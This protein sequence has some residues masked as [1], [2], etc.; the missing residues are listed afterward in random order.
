[1]SM[2]AVKGRKKWDGCGHLSSDSMNTRVTVNMTRTCTSVQLKA[3]GG[4]GVLRCSKN[5]S[6]AMFAMGHIFYCLEVNVE[7]TGLLI[8]FVNPVACCLTVRKKD[9][10]SHTKK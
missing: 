8:A 10:P 5:N 2:R 6:K 4:L 1:M 9:F 3:H 7:V